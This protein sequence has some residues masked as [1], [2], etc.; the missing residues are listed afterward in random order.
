VAV[1][2]GRV[3][4]IDGDEW[5]GRL[6]ARVLEEKGYTVEVCLE[7]RIGFRKACEVPYDC[8]VCSPDLPD[9]DGAWVARRVRTEGG[10]VSRTPFLF[11]GDFTDKNVRIQALQVGGDAFLRR[12]LSNEEI[13]AQVEALIAMS[14]RHQGIAE[15]SSPA[16]LSFPAAIRGDL[17]MFPL[18]SLLMM[19]ELER[20]SGTVDVVSSSGKRASLTI[21][22]GLFAHTE[23]GG[24]PKPALEVL[25]EVL[26]WRAG[27]FAFQPRESGMLPAPRASVG[28]LV[29]EAMRLEDE[30]KAAP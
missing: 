3:L 18:A 23:V 22:D 29:L 14:K 8:I 27:R 16:S 17:S 26:S 21:N 6:L 25:R 15:E 20:R 12:P 13:V 11:V 5:L 19:F 1:V 9:I 30:K 7:A 24:D 4:V 10:P 28:A 2:R